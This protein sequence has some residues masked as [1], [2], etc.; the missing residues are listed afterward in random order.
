VYGGDARGFNPNGIPGDGWALA[1][2]HDEQPRRL[3]KA[4]IVRWRWEDGIRLATVECPFC[5]SEHDHVVPV[6]ITADAR[7]QR[8]SKCDNR[9]PKR[10]YR[11]ALPEGGLTAGLDYIDAVDTLAEVQTD[12]AVDLTFEQSA[13]LLQVWTETPGLSRAKLA[14]GAA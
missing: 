8:T 9:R 2:E 6:D 1:R 14:G 12:P 7:L 10:D 4:Q 5:D 13:M 3:P 11:L